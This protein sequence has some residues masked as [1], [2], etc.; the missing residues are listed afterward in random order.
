MDIS[1]D[2]PV[3]ARDEILIAAPI[4]TIWD[5]QTDAADWPVLA[6]RG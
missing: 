5:I 3:I 4:P 1:A 2:A 6:A